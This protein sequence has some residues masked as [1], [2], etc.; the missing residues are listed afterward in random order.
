MDDPAAMGRWF[1]FADRMEL[2]EGAGVGRRQRMYGHWGRKQSEIDQ[3]V[4][5]YDAGRQ[6]AWEHVAERLDGRPAPRFA[7][8][9]LFRLTLEPA[10]G[11]CL[12][13]LESR[14]VPASRWR[15][16]VIRLF[17]VREVRQRLRQSADRLAAVLEP[18]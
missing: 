18:A 14:Q 8:S 12:V 2:V 15:G 4:V 17:G 10:D 6:L 3:R 5:E 13:R 1:A 11:G 7:A 9:T 16:V